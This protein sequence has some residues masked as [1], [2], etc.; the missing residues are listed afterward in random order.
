MLSTRSFFLLC[1]LSLLLSS[2]FLFS[3]EGRSSS[4]SYDDDADEDDDHST[5][6][7]NI[8]DEG[9]YQVQGVFRLPASAKF[10]G[11][12]VLLNGGEHIALVRAD[13][14]FEFHE[15]P[16]GTYVAE[17]FMVDY[18]FSPIRID[19]S[20]RERGRIRVTSTTGRQEKLPYPLQIRPERKAEYFQQREPYNFWGLLKNPMVIMMGITA[21][22]VIVMPRMM[23]NMDPEELEEMKRMQSKMSLNGMLKN[24]QDKAEKARL[25]SN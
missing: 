24:L 11:A 10:N 5:S 20:T 15:L 19:V 25:E 22:M 1:I 21:F 7:S 3:V 9:R 2:L 23:S 14:T 18:V 16:A 6:D 12:K 17:P 4:S 13:G 8:K